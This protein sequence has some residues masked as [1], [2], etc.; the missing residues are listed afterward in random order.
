VARPSAPLRLL[1]GLGRAQR[2]LA[3]AGEP[4]EEV[5]SFLGRIDLFQKCS[6][7]GQAVI[8]SSFLGS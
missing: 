6:Q 2:S 4:F 7:S 8:L 3:E 1:D 5:S